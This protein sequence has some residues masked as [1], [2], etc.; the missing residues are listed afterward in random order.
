[1]N[2][3]MMMMNTCA[4]LYIL[5]GFWTFVCIGVNCAVGIESEEKQE[6]VTLKFN[7]TSAIHTQILTR[8][9]EKK[10]GQINVRNIITVASKLQDTNQKKSEKKNIKSENRNKT[11]EKLHHQQYLHKFS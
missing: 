5:V 8:P 4:P 9:K 3:I 1:M 10:K 6:N 2:M 7:Q 11:D